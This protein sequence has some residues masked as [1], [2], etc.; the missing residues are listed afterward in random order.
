MAV[1]A[2]LTVSGTIN[3]SYPDN[4]AFTAATSIFPDMLADN[5]KR[6]LGFMGGVESSDIRCGIL[7]IEEGAR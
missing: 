7:S 6:A 1:K 5:I 2:K 3:V 4:T